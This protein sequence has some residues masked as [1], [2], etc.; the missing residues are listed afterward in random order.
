MA[1]Q[2]LKTKTTPNERNKVS[3]FGDTW[4][5]QIYCTNNYDKNTVIFGHIYFFILKE[6]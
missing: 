3:W 1:L 4:I 5:Y 6:E 2:K